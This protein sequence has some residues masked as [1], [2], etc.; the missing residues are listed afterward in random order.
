ME[1]DV[2]ELVR[3][4]RL[5]EAAALAEAHGD[6]RTA[7]E[8]FERACDW[9]ASANA[10]LNGGDAARALVLAAIGGADASAASALEHARATMTTTD[11]AR[12][13][14]VLRQRGQ[15]AWAARTYEAAGAEDSAAEMWERAGDRVRAAQL[16]EGSQDAGGGDG[17]GAVRAARV[18]EAG[19]R[20]EPDRADLL[21]ALGGLL[22]RCGK[23]TPALRALQRVPDD[24][25]EKLRALQLSLQALSALG[26]NDAKA[27]VVAQL[28]ARGQT[29][30]PDEVALEPLGGGAG[31]KARLYGRYEVVREVSSTATARLLECTD[32]LRGERV[33]VKLFSAT[34][35]TRG[36][37]RDALA[38]FAREARVLAQLAH[39]NVVPLH[40]VLEQ[41][42][43][44]VLEWMPGGTLEQH[45]RDEVFTPR[46]A[47]D[48][49]CAILGALG[50]A[51][52]LGVV[53]RDLKPANI[54]F[55]ASGTPRLS[56]FG[57]AHLG[58]LSVTA[59][60]GSFGSLAYMSPE[61]REGRPATAQSDIFGMGVVL[62]EMLTGQR[63]HVR[64]RGAPVDAPLATVHRYLDARHDA[65]VGALLAYDPRAR[66]E[67][68]FTAQR[69]LTTL[70]WPSDH[71]ASRRI[72]PQVSPSSVHPPPP[73][74]EL[75]GANAEL[76]T[77]GHDRWLE[78]RVVCI[79]LTPRAL[80]RVSLFARASHVALQPVLRVDRDAG[81]VWLGAPRGTLLARRLDRLERG[82]LESAVHRLHREGFAHG[83]IGRETVAL[84]DGGAPQ[85]LFP[86]VEHAEASV[87]LDLAALAKL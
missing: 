76:P 64:S 3:A 14:D 20:R 77:M 62:Y 70:P 29:V 84:V 15:L 58:D 8:L 4:Q 68:A 52:R 25:A 69:A 48:I 73:R 75:A 81:T 39:P 34:D 22:L 10:A 49:A 59:T 1:E 50:E 61:Q 31:V 66:P 24:S 40:E 83:S 27:A 38:H 41:G 37:G 87:L 53:H 30:V 19:L 67:G 60:A 56:D 55:D 44:L 82:L 78:R 54:L 12:L 74:L 72:E 9:R 23:A 18:L 7:S 26:M 51:H 35:A 47:V 28:L 86:L 32:V 36:S 6:L 16:H 11:L 13:A 17:H 57:V 45:L 46:R 79:S 71:D 33:A 2:A 5:V 80:E 63:A 85:L 21:L 65:A 42:P 43:A